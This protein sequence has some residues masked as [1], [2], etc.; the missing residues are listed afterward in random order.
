MYGPDIDSV[1]EKQITMPVI[2]PYDLEQFLVQTISDALD[3]AGMSD[4]QSDKILIPVH[5]QGKG[6]A[7]IPDL[8]DTAGPRGN[9]RIWIV[10]NELMWAGIDRRIDE[11]FE[12]LWALLHWHNSATANQYFVRLDEGDA[13]VH[14]ASSFRQRL[15]PRLDTSNNEADA[16]I[17][18]AEK[19]SKESTA[20]YARSAKWKGLTPR[21]AVLFKRW[22]F[23]TPTMC[24]R[25]YNNYDR[26]MLFDDDEDM[27]YPFPDD[28]FWK[29]GDEGDNVCDGVPQW[30]DVDMEEEEHQDAQKE[31]EEG[32]KRKRE[33]SDLSQ[34]LV[35]PEI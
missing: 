24:N 35:V 17:Q 28:L 31:K 20:A 8:Y 6:T 4:G 26:H 19:E 30:H 12:I 3:E 9:F 27:L 21:E 7:I 14:L 16:P 33:N 13:L 5:E 10:G 11:V 18:E 2:V 34:D 32:R 23:H 1:F 25:S 15:P 29:D 22:A